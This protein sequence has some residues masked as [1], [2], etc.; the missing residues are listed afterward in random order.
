MIKQFGKAPSGKRLERIKQADNYRNDSFQNIEETSVN[1]NNV[2]MFKMMKDMRNRPKSVNPSKKVPSVKTNLNTIEAEEPAFVWF[3]HSS[4]LLKINEYTILVDPVFSGNASPVSF[5]GKA[6]DGANEYGVDDMPEVDVLLLTHDHYD[7]LDYPTISKLKTK[8]KSVV[9]SLGVGAHLEYWGYST[10]ML[11][12][13]NWWESV[14]IM[15]DFKITATPSRHFSGRLFKRGNTLWS[16]FVLEVFDYKLYLGGDSG[17]SPQFKEIGDTFGPFD[18]AI[19]ECGQYGEDWPQ[20]H[21]FP[22]QVVIAANDLKAK[23]VIPVHWAKF[24]L[25]MHPWNEPIKRFTKAADE[26]GLSYVS[27]KIGELYQ[28]NQEFKQEVW[29]DFE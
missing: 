16:S 22:E 19:L 24:T 1:P 25:A 21:K 3:G 7:H 2:S 20:I 13:L 11:T 14:E 28:L 26:E 6:Y 5:F 10:K 9:C 27:P 23:K 17:Y 18:L 12:E 15:N 29:W 4:Y 8:V